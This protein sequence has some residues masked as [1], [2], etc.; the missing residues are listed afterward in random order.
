MAK[1]Y[2]PGDS[3]T[4]ERTTELQA[5]NDDKKPMISGTIVPYGSFAVLYNGKSYEERI[6]FEKG[7]F[8]ESLAQGGGADGYSSVV[9]LFNHNRDYPLGRLDAGTLRLDD[10]DDG[11]KYEV[12]IDPDD[13]EGMRVYRLVQR[14]TVR[15]SSIGIQMSDTSEQEKDDGRKTVYTLTVEKAFI[16]DASVVTS[17]AILDATALSRCRAS[18]QAAIAASHREFLRA[19]GLLPAKG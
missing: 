12:D 18:E 14:G 19:A 3:F 4:F 10:T 8:T 11:L 9:A 7:C 2:N 13:P 15:G 16:Y 6:T 17:P 5:G 1:R